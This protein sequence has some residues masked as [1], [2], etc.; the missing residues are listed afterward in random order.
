MYFTR[1]ELE[2][3][4]S[5]NDKRIKNFF[6]TFGFVVIRQMIPKKDFKMLLKNMIRYTINMKYLEMVVK[7]LNHVGINYLIALILKEKKN[8]A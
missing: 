6:D 3:S 7:K 2:H 1:K 8:S 5:F 4:I